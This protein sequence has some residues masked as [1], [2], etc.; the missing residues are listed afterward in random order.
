M[1][2]KR[3]FRDLGFIDEAAEGVKGKITQYKNSVGFVTPSEK[4]TSAKL[5]TLKIRRQKRNSGTGNG[6]K[7]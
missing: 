1:S 6:S 3:L 2:T 4:M 7:F 5:K